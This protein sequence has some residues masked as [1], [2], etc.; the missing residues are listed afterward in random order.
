MDKRSYEEKWRSDRNWL[1]FE[2]ESAE[3]KAD[4]LEEEVK[5]IK[6]LKSAF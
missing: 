6:S 2:I 3:M 1:I 5:K 4:V